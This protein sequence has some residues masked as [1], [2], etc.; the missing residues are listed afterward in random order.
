MQDAA[1]SDMHYETGVLHPSDVGAVNLQEASRANQQY[2]AA[3][4]D[5]REDAAVQHQ[6]PVLQHS[7]DAHDLAG[8]ESGGKQ[9]N[10]KAS[11]SHIVKL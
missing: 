10:F 6:D 9:L 11:Q 7:V 5:L 3:Q 8:Y 2:S 1:V 4:P